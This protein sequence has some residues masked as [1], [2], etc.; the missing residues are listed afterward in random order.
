MLIHKI[1]LLHTRLT[2]PKTHHLIPN[3]NKLTTQTPQ[4]SPKNSKISRRRNHRFPTGIKPSEMDSSNRRRRADTVVRRHLP[5]AVGLHL[6]LP[7]QGSFGAFHKQNVPPEHLQRRPHLPRHAAKPVEPRL[8]CL[9]H[10]DSGSTFACRSEH[11][12]PGQLHSV[13]D[14]QGEQVTV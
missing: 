12:L 11:P 3:D 1:R 8:R 9:V 10:I 7:Q 4:G 5:A 2:H 14:V 6:K 13:Q